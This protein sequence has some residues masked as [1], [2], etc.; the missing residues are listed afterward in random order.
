MCLSPLLIGSLAPRAILDDRAAGRPDRFQCSHCPTK[1]PHCG[2]T[3]GH[4]PAPYRPAPASSGGLLR[5]HPSH[6]F[7]PN[8][9]TFQQYPLRPPRIV[10]DNPIN[11]RIEHAVHVIH[12]VH[13]PGGY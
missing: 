9:P 11:A 1:C 8:Q 3:G 12:F 13:G 7:V 10:S 2:I 5:H 4:K 6:V